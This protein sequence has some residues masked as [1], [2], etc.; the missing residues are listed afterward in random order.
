MEAAKGMPD[1]L[2]VKSCELQTSAVAVIYSYEEFEQNKSS[3]A[4]SLS[5]ALSETI[6]CR[7]GVGT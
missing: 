2:N 5:Y 4:I 3:G 6:H 1:G 7:I